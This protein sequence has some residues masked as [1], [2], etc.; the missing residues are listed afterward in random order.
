MMLHYTQF[1][2]VTTIP[3]KTRKKINGKMQSVLCDD[4]IYTLD[5][6]TTSLFVFA[7]R[8]EKFDKTKP[9]E[10]YKTAV[11]VGYMYIWT[12]SV[13]DTVY[14]GRTG[15][16]L[17]EFMLMIKN[18]VKMRFIVYVHNLSFDFQFIRNYITD[19]DVFARSPRQPLT[20]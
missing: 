11:S 9:P 12:L 3:I 8:T 18:A 7:D 10:Y 19:F 4:N 5:T 17:L 13:N 14:Y 6:E 2:T 20:A 15:A 1:Q 16:E